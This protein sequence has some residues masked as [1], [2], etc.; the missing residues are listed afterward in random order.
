MTWTFGVEWNEWHDFEGCFGTAPRTGDANRDR[1]LAVGGTA[2]VQPTF[3]PSE[4]DGRAQ[5]PVEAEFGSEEKKAGEDPVLD[6][7][8]QNRDP[9]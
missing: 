7:A 9:L 3:T 6:A 4:Y 2:A 5:P 1:P 8:V